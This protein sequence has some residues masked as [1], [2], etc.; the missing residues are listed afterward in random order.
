MKRTQLAIVL[1]FGMGLIAACSG[2]AE[3][4]LEPM[5]FNV[6]SSQVGASVEAS[7]LGIVFRPP[8]GWRPMP[9]GDL[10]MATRD[11]AGNPLGVQPQYM[12]TQPAIDALLM[13]ATVGRA[14]GQTLDEQVKRYNELLNAEL[15]GAIVKE[16]KYLKDGIVVVQL[17]T[18]SEDFVT[19]TLFFEAS[20]DGLL[21]FDYIVPR[22]SYPGQ[23]K[24]IES[25]I[26]SIQ[27][28]E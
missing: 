21:Q 6:D 14:E 4:D 12:F 13:V 15:S 9:A 19:F 27:L 26:G 2:G 17:L 7:K 11:V 1:L 10:E 20:T 25:S 22:A 18:Q 28:V 5:H 8:A 3:S 16:D 24:A 23:V